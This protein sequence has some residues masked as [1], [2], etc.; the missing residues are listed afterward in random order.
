MPKTNWPLLKQHKGLQR[1]ININWNNVTYVEHIGGG[2][3]VI[4]FVGGEQVT[5]EI[6][7][8]PES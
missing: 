8:L 6:I 2:P 1:H 5:V 4:H 3:A 7:V